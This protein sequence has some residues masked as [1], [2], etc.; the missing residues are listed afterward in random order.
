[1]KKIFI[2]LFLQ[3]SIFIANAQ[4]PTCDIGA[5]T[6]T[7]MLTGPLMCGSSLSDYTLTSTTDPIVYKLNIHIFKRQFSQPGVYDNVTINDVNYF[8]TL[9]NQQY[10]TLSPPQLPNVPLA[11][12]ISNTK[13]QFVLNQYLTHVDDIAFQPN[14]YFNDVAIDNLYGVDRDKA[15]N[16]YFISDPVN[17]GGGIGLQNYS[18]GTFIG[19][20]SSMWFP[21]LAGLW[22][23]ELGHSLGYLCHTS[24][25]Q[26][27]IGGPTISDV[28]FEPSG[29]WN[30][31]GVCGSNTTMPTPTVASNNIMGYNWQCRSYLSPEQIASFYYMA[32]SWGS[33]YPNSGPMV[34]S[35]QC[36]YDGT[37]SVIVTSDET[38]TMPRN[39]RGNLIVMPGVHL[40]IK[41]NVNMTTSSRAIVKIGGKLTL[42][43]GV[44]I[45]GCN[46]L[47]PGIFVEGSTSDQS[48]D[49]NG[50]PYYQG[51]V[52]VINNGKIE[53][54]KTA[55]STLFGLSPSGGG[56]VQCTQ[57]LFQSNQEDIYLGPYVYIDPSKPYKAIPNESFFK[58]CSFNSNLNLQGG[59]VK[60]RN[61]NLFKVRDVLIA[62]CSFGTS[63]GDRAINSLDA[64]F[65]LKDYCANYPSCTGLIRNTFTSNPDYFIYSQ[66]TTNFFPSVVDHCLI[67]NSSF[68]KTGFYFNYGNYATITNN[69]FTMGNFFNYP[70]P[71]PQTAIYLDN[72]TGF[73]VEN[74]AMWAFTGVPNP[75]M[76]IV[77]N[78]SG[79]YANSVYN[80]KMT[81][82]YQ[83]IWAQN[84]NVD[85]TS[86]VG[87]KM[88]CNDFVNCDYNI[89]VQKSG[90]S[91][92][93]PN[94]TGVAFTQ[95]LITGNDQQRVR[96]TYN[97]PACGSE[98]KYYINTGNLL[99]LTHG[100]FNAF[101]SYAVNDLH[102]RPQPS[103][104]N[105][106]EITTIVGAPPSNPTK[107]IYCPQAYPPSF[108][109]LML[110]TE[111]TLQRKQI[112][113]LNNT[114]ATKV[115]GGNTQGLL[116]AINNPA[117]SSGSLKNLL[118]S[119]GPYLSDQV[120]IA[121]YNTNPPYGH[122][123]IIHEINAPVSPAVYQKILS[124]NL[125]SGVLEAINTNQNQ[126]AL[127]ARRFLEAQITLAKTEL[128]LILNEK[129]RRCLNDS[130]NPNDSIAFILAQNEIQN[131]SYLQITNL[132]SARKYTEAEAR[133]HE[134]QSIDHSAVDFCNIQTIVLNLAKDPKYALQLATDNATKESLL[135]WALSYDPMIEGPAKA[136][137]SG[138]YNYYIEEEKLSPEQIT[139]ARF[140]NNE[141]TSQQQ[142]IFL[143]NSVKVYPNPAQNQL[144]V[145]MENNNASTLEIRD[146]TGKLL[147]TQNIETRGSINI[148]NLENGIYFINLVGN[149]GLI[150]SKK[151]T[152]LK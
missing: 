70:T 12:F 107:G 111:A 88:N 71:S 20:A 83:G 49:A 18:F 108:T 10:S 87:L 125:P 57:A 114:M 96:N 120:M 21:G 92:A 103:C 24:A 16:I 95:G 38:W 75:A 40:T 30:V 151:I 39:I 36:D 127:S 19:P 129:T 54:A 91:L 106:N 51:M 117:I 65:I 150:S 43:G 102:P 41:C 2:L 82:L 15:F 101:G 42:D 26:T 133:I 45:N 67:T 69:D 11:P 17:N 138:I 128:G 59:N 27:G 134:L 3:L 46:N 28:Y 52:E 7:P 8:I 94:N 121:F 33:P 148:E 68:K 122:D 141:S 63:S 146:V 76:G 64:S 53:N 130:I 5:R 29:I 14:A 131:S 81:N 139:N 109:N 74:N 56:I 137:L 149:T 99:N 79:P 73:V 31:A 89:G 66:N 44:M 112:A 23:H 145:E 84:Q 4:V 47:W 97:T 72:S 35:D 142:T 136:I 37:K 61:I 62:G 86:G 9:L 143:N 132:I 144:F 93:L 113:D 147:K 140:S 55:I 118:A 58:N 135:K 48:L 126:N 152:I 32:S 119:V 110:S 50:M 22:G 60:Q 98:N 80:N 100:S 105:I 6:T 115:D 90:R 104:S 13:I 25:P 123:K 78:N 124:L 116:D 1:M 34:Y 77:I 85:F